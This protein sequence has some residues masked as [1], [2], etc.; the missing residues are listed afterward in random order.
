MIKKN[1]SISTQA[2]CSV[3][4][5]SLVTATTLHTKVAPV[6]NT[7]NTTPSSLT[8]VED[9]SIIIARTKHKK[10]IL[11]EYE[12]EFGRDFLDS[13]VTRKK[14]KHSID[15][16]D[17]APIRMKPSI[18]K[19]YQVQE[20]KIYNIITMVITEFLESFNTTNMK[21]L[22]AINAD[23]SVMIPKTMCWLKIDF[24]LLRKPQHDYKQLTTISPRRV[25]M[26]SAA[27][28]HFGLD[29]RKLL[30]WLGGKY[31]GERREVNH[32][33]AAV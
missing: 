3:N 15:P 16:I 30:R 18:K 2:V 19:Y 4:T 8:R 24:S 26:T 12:S 5:R 31:T 17:P 14:G 27:M 7:V 13:I 11:Q 23:F 28:I 10:R 32:M 21:N 25:E 22:L 1:V 6:K 33:L 20:L 29:P 9:N